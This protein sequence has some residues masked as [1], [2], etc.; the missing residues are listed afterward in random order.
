MAENTSVT[1]PIKSNGFTGFHLKMIALI[2]MFIDHVATV[3]IWRIY[4]ASYRITGS[5]QISESFRDRIIV[6]VAE[7]QDLVYNIYEMM[8]YIGRMAFPIYCFLLVEGFLHTRSVKKYALRLLLFAFISEIPFDLAIDAKWVS[9]DYSNVF[10]TL[11]LGLLLIW[12]VSYIE[13]F[14]EFWCEKEWDRFLGTLLVVMAVVVVLAIC[15]G[16]AEMVLLTDYGLAG[17]VAILSLY[18][19]RRTKELGFAV[20]VLSL[21]VLSSDTEILALL[22]LYP[23]MKYNGE[24]GKSIKY[25]FYAF[26]PIH[27]LVLA[28]ICMGMGV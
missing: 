3:V 4:V 13:K 10:F 6:W 14:Y 11:L 25:V 20:A 27:L 12:A 24:R 23:L 21:T 26:Y 7:N 1:Q 22:M 17:V 19:L 5:M 2:T 18:L 9:M 28:L 8:R 15:G 16:F